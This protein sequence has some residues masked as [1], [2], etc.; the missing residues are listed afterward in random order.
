MQARN[1]YDEVY[2]EKHNLERDY[3]LFE[4]GDDKHDD[5]PRPW[6][7][8]NDNNAFVRLRDAWIKYRQSNNNKDGS[9]KHVMLVPMKIEIF[10]HKIIVLKIRQHY[11]FSTTKFFNDY[12]CASHIN[13]YKIH[14][15]ILFD[16]F[17]IM[18]TCFLTLALHLAS[19][20]IP[21]LLKAHW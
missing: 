21:V 20:C 11:M 12:Y 9:A 10:I 3:K 5:Q 7:A 19:L 8:G 6:K 17:A 13:T 18:V 15:L 16:Y 4:L 1:K 2:K 14:F